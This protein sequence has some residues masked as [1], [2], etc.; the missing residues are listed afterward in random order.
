MEDEIKQLIHVNLPIGLTQ[1]IDEYVSKNSVHDSRSS[2]MRELLKIGLW[3]AN[4]KKEFEVIF[5]NP[6]LMEELGSQYN[7]GGLVDYAQ[8]MNTREF[9][10]V[11]SIFKNEA[12]TRKLS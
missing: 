11:Y 8:R 4:R 1:Q 3:F 7:E 10:I 9:S 6:E 2:A 5:N 12:K